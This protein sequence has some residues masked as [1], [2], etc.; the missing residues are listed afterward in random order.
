M[1]ALANEELNRN[2]VLHLLGF[3]SVPTS[4][5]VSMSV[6]EPRTVSQRCADQG[7]ARSSGMASCASILEK[8]MSVGFG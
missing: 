6:S 3:F 7:Q 2:A 4:S 8:D 1:W 5:F